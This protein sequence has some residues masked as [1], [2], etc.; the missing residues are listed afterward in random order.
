[1]M[2]G[3][4]NNGKCSRDGGNALVGP[5]PSAAVSWAE[6]RPW[7]DPTYDSCPCTSAASYGRLPRIDIP[8]QGKTR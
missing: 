6:A 3:W 1:M 7:A 4:T 8:I 5:E 2:N